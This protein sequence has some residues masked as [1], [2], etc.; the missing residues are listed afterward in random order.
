M[1]LAAADAALT[2]L[3]K[4]LGSTNPVIGRLEQ[5]IV[6]VSGELATL[7][8]RYTNDHSEVI[9]A[10]RK[11]QRLQDE[12]RQVLEASKGIDT[13]DIDRLWNIAAGLTQGDRNAPPLLVTQMQNLQEAQSR[14]SALGQDVEQLRR[15]IGDLQATMAA[16]AS[17][18]QRHQQLERALAQARE[19]HDSLAKRYEMA[20]VTGA[21]GA[22]EA[23]ERIKIADATG[24]PSQPNSPPRIVFLLGAL[25][26]GL[27]LGGALAFLAEMFDPSVRQA[28]DFARLFGAPLLGRLPRP[29]VPGL[30]T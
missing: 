4:R 21:L 9:G 24:D 16:S 20:R 14:R 5:D 6:Q 7:R 22:F 25:V 28:V 26:A 3:R 12:R 11:L 2:D 1:A 18:E 30:A 15:S 8:A 13:Q 19:A 27:A 23:P 29:V 17:I 10:E